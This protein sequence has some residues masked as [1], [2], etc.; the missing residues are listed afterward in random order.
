[1]FNWDLNTPVLVFFTICIEMG[2]VIRQILNCRY[3]HTLIKVK[4]LP[5]QWTFICSF[6]A[7]CFYNIPDFSQTNINGQH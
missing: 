7:Q 1:M 5:T 2:A 3:S 6:T 4:T